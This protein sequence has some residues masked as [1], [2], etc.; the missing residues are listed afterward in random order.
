MKRVR[1]ATKRPKS[2]QKTSWSLELGQF[3]KFSRV[4]EHQFDD[5]RVIRVEH[6]QEDRPKET[7]IGNVALKLGGLLLGLF[8]PTTP[9]DS[10]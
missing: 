4:E 1:G 10:T 7:S 2:T 8:D 9:H 5:L 6:V 3:L